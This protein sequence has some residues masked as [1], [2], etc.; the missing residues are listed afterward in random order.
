MICCFRFCV[1]RTFQ[2][3]Q[4]VVSSPLFDFNDPAH[5]RMDFLC[6]I[7]FVLESVQL[8]SKLLHCASSHNQVSSIV[9]KIQAKQRKFNAGILDHELIIKTPILLGTQRILDPFPIYQHHQSFH[10]TLHLVICDSP[11]PQTSR[12]IHLLCSLPLPRPVKFDPQFMLLYLHI[13]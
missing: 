7:S 8:T 11:N 1:G 5:N 4:E 10:I 9:A 3:K 2:G 6:G 12:F 13:R